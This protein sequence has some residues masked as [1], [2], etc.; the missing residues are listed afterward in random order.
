[1]IK[2]RLKNIFASTLLQHTKTTIDNFYP[3]IYFLT[4]RPYSIST[5]K[6][7]TY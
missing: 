6:F 4:Y 7:K 3:T 2:T 5:L 1:M